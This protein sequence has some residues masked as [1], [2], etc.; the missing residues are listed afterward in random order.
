MGRDDVV[1][2]GQRGA[3]AGPEFADPAGVTADAFLGGALKVLQPA[4]GYRAG[5]DAVLLAAAAP[6]GTGRP[7]R[8]L[9]AGA[10]VGTV[11]LCVARRMPD[12]RVDLVEMQPLLA[13]LARRNVAANSLSQRLNVFEADILSPAATLAAA[14]L[15]GEH[16]DVVLA[17]PPYHE[18]GSGTASTNP[19]KAGAN[20]MPPGAL[21]DW[22]RAMARFCRPGGQA[23]MIHKADALD[24]VL[25]VLSRRF[26]ALDVLGL[27]SR[28]GAPAGRVLVRGTKGSRAPL[29][30]LAGFVVHGSDGGFTDKADAILRD[31]AG[32]DLAAMGARTG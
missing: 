25:A 28:A 16:Y 11:G 7:V 23:V 10:G 18:E 6:G 22:A 3:I 9:D 5:I 14:G 4:R 27:H 29:R 15:S 32:L 13:D 20:A 24:E 12:A 19:V 17:N 1:Q 26:G 21:D 2:V 8:V 31:G 30:L